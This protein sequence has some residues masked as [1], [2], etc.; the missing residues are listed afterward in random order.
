[1]LWV[2][3]SEE[4]RPGDVGNGSATSDARCISDPRRE[5]ETLRWSRAELNRDT[6]EESLA[7]GS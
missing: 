6:A 7:M 3:S 1:M 5:G 4:N 2:C